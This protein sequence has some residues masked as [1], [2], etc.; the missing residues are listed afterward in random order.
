MTDAARQAA[1]AEAYLQAA[2]DA[3]ASA[4]A[5]AGQGGR[6]DQLNLSAFALGRLVGGGALDRD[7]AEEA[8]T[9]A[10]KDACLDARRIT[11]T[12][13]RALDAGALQPREIPPPREDTNGTLTG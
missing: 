2:L 10:A 3:E 11:P 8:L 9:R 7:R 5:G 6:N 13:R 1:L 12:L 4:V